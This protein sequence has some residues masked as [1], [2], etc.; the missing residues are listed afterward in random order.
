MRKLIA[1]ILISL[2]IPIPS[3]SAN[4]SSYQLVTPVLTTTYELPAETYNSRW[5]TI[6][7]PFSV[8]L[9]SDG[10]V[11]SFHFDLID[12]EGFT[13]AS[14]E[15]IS[16]NNLKFD[17]H[18]DPVTWTQNN[19]WTLYS[20][21]KAKLPIRLQTEIE[22][23]RSTGKSS[24]VQT[25]PM[26]FV[27]HKDDVAEKAQTNAVAKAQAEAVAKAQ[28]EAQRVLAEAK[29]IADA[30]A[31]AEAD[32]L[33]AEKAITDAK[34]KADAEAKAKVEAELKAKQEA[35]AKVKA[36]ADAKAKA[37]AEADAKAIAEFKA[38]QDAEAKAKA[39]AEAA[40][41]AKKLSPIWLCTNDPTKN[42]M[43]Y[44][45]AAIVCAQVDKEINDKKIAEEKAIAMQLKRDLVNGSPCTKLNAK[46]IAGE[47]IFTCK[48]INKKLIWR[49]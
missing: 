43:T 41:L 13:L 11:A 39:D 21:D 7:I 38:K 34:A 23:W 2:L 16:P 5:R 10:T 47:K 44:S 49:M 24:I 4:G 3:A 20:F 29:A 32:R 36:E 26:N 14:K 19:K 18:F 35:E 31:K 40:D 48:K 22:F 17:T 27:T 46:K 30:K 1:L 45:E 28:A 6:E 42:K 25:F 37:Q 9:I 8:I 33:A 15:N 12:A